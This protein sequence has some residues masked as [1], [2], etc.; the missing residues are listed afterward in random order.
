[1]LDYVDDESMRRNVQ[2]ALNIGESFH[3]MQRAIASVN[4]GDTIRGRNEAELVLWNE[5]SKFIANCI[6]YYNT[7]ILSHLLKHYRDEGNL[8]GI[9]RVT[10]ASPVA[11]AHITMSGFYNCSSSND[12]AYEVNRVI[13]EL[14][15]IA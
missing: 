4:G 1:M 15:M 10:H 12:D 13:E 5:S 8:E 14:K 7:Y 9:E 6:L 11:W 2:S 3:Q